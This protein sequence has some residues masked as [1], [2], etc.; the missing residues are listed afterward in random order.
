[1]VKVTFRFIFQRFKATVIGILLS[2]MGFC[3]LILGTFK[4]LVPPVA[5]I[6]LGLFLIC[7]EAEL[8][9]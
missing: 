4:N 9:K 6:L 8:R 3:N 2:I 7:V 1:M 5:I